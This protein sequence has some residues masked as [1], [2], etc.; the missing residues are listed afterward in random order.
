MEETE[1]MFLN[2]NNQRMNL[3]NHPITS[4]ISKKQKMFMKEKI[5]VLVLNLLLSR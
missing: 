5:A 1:E 2:E 4:K 3:N